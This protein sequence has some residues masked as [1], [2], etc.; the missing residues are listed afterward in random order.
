M[1]EKSCLKLDA[2]RYLVALLVHL[3]LNRKLQMPKC[4][5]G[6]KRGRGGK[7]KMDGLTSP[8]AAMVIGSTGLSPREVLTFSI[9]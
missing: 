1:D 3:M 7:Q 6:R 5:Q 4:Q 2:E 8:E 9:A